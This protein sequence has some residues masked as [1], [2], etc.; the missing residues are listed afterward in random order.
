MHYFC[1][2]YLSIGGSTDHRIEPRHLLE[3]GPQHLLETQRLLQSL[4]YLRLIIRHILNMHMHNA[5]YI[6]YTR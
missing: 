2:E 6:K 3:R 4:R 5:A 1:G